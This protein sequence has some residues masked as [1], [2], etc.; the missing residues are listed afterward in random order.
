MAEGRRL[1]SDGA[2]DLH[3]RLALPQF[4]LICTSVQ[5]DKEAQTSSSGINDVWLI[6]MI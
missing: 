5:L 3:T 4:D 1:Y 6:Y 2:E